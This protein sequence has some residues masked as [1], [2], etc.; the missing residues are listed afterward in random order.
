MRRTA[1]ILAAL[2][3]V[4]L[5]SFIPA[6]AAHAGG[7]P[8]VQRYTIGG[9]G[10]PGS[11]HVPHVPAGNRV[12]ITYPADVMRGDYSRSV[13]QGKLDRAARSYR[14]LWPDKE[15]MTWHPINSMCSPT[16]RV[17]VGTSS[18]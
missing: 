12:Y 14:T 13:A 7:C 8:S 5:I 15:A 10:D 2:I 3:T 16:T 17:T 18:P 1:L 6:P 11:R 4:S 9:T